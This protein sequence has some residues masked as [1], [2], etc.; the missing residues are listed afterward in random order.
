MQGLLKDPA[1]IAARILDMG[2]V[3]SLVEKAVENFDK[4]EAEKLAKRMKK[5]EMDFNDLAGQL[6][7]MRTLGGM[8]GILG[9]LPGVGKV[10]DQIAA[11]GLDDKMLLRQEAIISSMTKKE[12][13]NPDLMNGSRRKRIAQGAGVD[14]SEVNKLCKMQRQMADVMKKMGKMGNKGLPFGMGGINPNM[15]QGLGLPPNLTR[16]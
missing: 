3:V 14:V 8:Q 15:L 5:G 13:Q 10:K 9:M 11:A 2:D 4:E 16:K 7:Q 6:R 1:R 12:R